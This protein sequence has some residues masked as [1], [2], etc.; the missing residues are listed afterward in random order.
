MYPSK[1]TSLASARNSWLDCL[2]I[3][4]LDIPSSIDIRP[5]EGRWTHM[6]QMGFVGGGTEYDNVVDWDKGKLERINGVKILCQYHIFIDSLQLSTSV[7]SISW[8]R[9][10]VVPGT[11]STVCLFRT[12][13]M[14][15]ASLTVCGF[16]CAQSSSSAGTGPSFPHVHFLST[17]VSG[18][19]L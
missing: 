3:R 12:Q 9:P 8:L 7:R 14:P 11:F 1:R 17:V 4:E 5:V 10:V 6:L 15:E 16:L 18:T 2:F 13:S 19:S